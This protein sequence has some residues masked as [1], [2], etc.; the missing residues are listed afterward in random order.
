MRKIG[1]FVSDGV[2]VRNYLYSDVVSGVEKDV[3]VLHNF[4]YASILY[5]KEKS[6]I[7]SDAILPKYKESFFEKFYR[8][9]IHKARL[10]WN[11]ALVQN[12]TILTNYNP[13]RKKVKNNFF[14]F[15]IDF[16]CLFIKSYDSILSL[17]KRYERCL[18]NNPIYQSLKK[19]LSDLGLG[20]IL[21]THQRAIHAPIVFLAAKEIGIRTIAVI[22]SWDNLPKGRLYLKAD[23]YLVWSDY[24]KKEMQ[25]FF[26]EIH[27][28]Q[29]AVTGT[30]Q[31]D[32]SLKS[33]NIIDKQL[34]YKTYNLDAN[35]TNICFSANDLTSPHEASYL[36]DL[37]QNLR[38]QN[39]F[40]KYQLLF[41]INP[42]DISGRFDELL[43]S[44]KDVIKSIT[45][46]WNNK[47][48]Q[49]WSFI[50][51]S[52]DDV[53][54]LTS[55]CYYSDII[56]NVGSTMVFDFA[57][58]NKPCIYIKYN[59]F[60]NQKWDI[61]TVYDFQHFRSM[62]NDNCVGWVKSKDGYLEAIETALKKGN[63]KNEWL[64]VVANN[65]GSASQNIQK[66][67]LALV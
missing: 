9:L 18:A 15:L 19:Q 50:F 44:N 13:S 63:F 23:K 11:A 24:M 3:V 65:I 59:Q 32:F 33:E 62:P 6:G 2:G 45:P 56:I 46:K 1:L 35:K 10:R 29:I 27:S 67:I 30:P 39:A 14:Y 64:D 53:Q 26:P 28:N 17:E 47:G 57:I 43:E 40:D 20:V 51:P 38:N 5:V 52:L 12:K 58:F 60:E 31:F 37:I 55:T 54:L 22:Y 42:V 49:S 41:R 4:D 21:C 36:R 61:N 16:G 34:F 66:E 8:E 48:S 7:G 25:S